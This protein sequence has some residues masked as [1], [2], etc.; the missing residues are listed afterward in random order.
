MTVEKGAVSLMFQ[1]FCPYVNLYSEI[2]S[3]LLERISTRYL[4]TRTT[5][6]A[7]LGPSDVSMSLELEQVR[8]K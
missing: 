4:R 2:R 5:P 8:A 6:L 1:E 7:N 3:Q